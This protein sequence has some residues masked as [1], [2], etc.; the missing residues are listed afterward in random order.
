MSY[1]TEWTEA[2]IQRLKLLYTSEKLFD[3]I[4]EAFPGRTSNAIR[5]KASRLGLRRP[6]PTSDIRSQGILLISEGYDGHYNYL[7]RCSE[8]GSWIQVN[9]EDVA[10]ESSIAVCDKC[11]STCYMSA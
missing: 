5:I 8:C 9:G 3:E 4:V 11:G 2:E 7:L 6:T 10:E 1:V